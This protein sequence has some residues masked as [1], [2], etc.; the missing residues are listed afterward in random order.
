[1]PTASVAPSHARVHNNLF[2]LGAQSRNL[3]PAGTIEHSSSIAIAEL[4]A[5]HLLHLG[6]R[7]GGIRLESTAPASGNRTSLCEVFTSFAVPI[8]ADS[9]TSA[10]DLDVGR[11]RRI[12]AEKQGD[13]IGVIESSVCP[14]LLRTP[15]DGQ[16][17]RTACTVP[18]SSFGCL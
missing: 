12:A 2:K 6:G 1:M 18:N 8:L 7:L 17:R 11:V 15:H 4:L 5:G 13:I 10:G 3:N 9:L 16:V 14:T